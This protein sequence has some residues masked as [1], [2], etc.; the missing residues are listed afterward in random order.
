MLKDHMTTA[1]AAEYLGYKIASIC[2]LCTNNKLPGATKFGKSWAIPKQSVY[3]Y[4]RGLQ[5]FAAV[6]AHK[7]EEEVLRLAEIN[8]AI[9]KYGH[10][11]PAIA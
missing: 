1:E 4:K 8:A 9:R 3:T 6:K 10:P 2:N 11:E 7:E 5:G